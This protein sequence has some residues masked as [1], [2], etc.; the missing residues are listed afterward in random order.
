MRKIS[1]YRP[2]EIKMLIIDEFRNASEMKKTLEMLYGDRFE[3][4]ILDYGYPEQ[5]GAWNI[6][7]NNVKD[8]AEE[9]LEE[10]YEIILINMTAWVFGDGEGLGVD[11]AEQLIKYCPELKSKILLHACRDDWEVQKMSGYS[12]ERLEKL[13]KSVRTTLYSENYQKC[14]RMLIEGSSAFQKAT[15]SKVNYD[16]NHNGLYI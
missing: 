7:Y 8:W 4:Y 3:K 13:F 15:L 10:G 12:N 14:L 11:L 1:V 16:L 5:M 2:E 6:N 9:F